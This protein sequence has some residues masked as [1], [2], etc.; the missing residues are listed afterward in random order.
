MD[1]GCGGGVGWAG[2]GF[3]CLLCLEIM[4]KSNIFNS[5]KT[6]APRT[7]QTVPLDVLLS[8]LQCEMSVKSLE[9]VV[10]IV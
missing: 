10:D 6:I 1:C 3:F 8:S 2:A 7:C 9:T 4:K 5:I